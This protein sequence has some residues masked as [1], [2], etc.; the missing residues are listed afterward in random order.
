MIKYL[1]LQRTTAAHGEEI[2]AAVRRVVE[3]GWYLLGNEVR[4]FEEDYAKYIGTDHCVACG[5]G[6]DALTL[7]LRAY[8]E[9]GVMKNGDEVIVP[10]NTYIATILAITATGHVP[11]RVETRLHTDEA[12]SHIASAFQIDDSLIE[13]AITERTRAIMIVHLYGACAYTERIGELCRKHNLKLIE[14]NAQAHGCKYCE[15]GLEGESAGNSFKQTKAESNDFKR[16]ENEGNSFKRTEDESAGRGFKLTGSLGDAA[17]HSFYPGKNLGALG[18]A[19]AVTTNDAELAQTIR[20]I[21]N[22]GSSRKYV[23]DYVGRNSRKD[24]LQAAVLRVKL[25][26]LDADN[27]RRREIARH[28]ISNIRHPKLQLPS[29]AYCAKSVHHIFPV[30]CEER[31]ALQQHLADSGIQTLIHYPVPPH[32]QQCYAEPSANS[33]WRPLTDQPLPITEL[34]HRQELSLPLYPALTDSEIEQ[35]INSVNCFS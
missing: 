16:T 21:A 31:D 5:N 35:I 11:R 4:A 33:D 18:D 30:L 1:D 6:L 34:I 8:K 29:E 12:R 9:L 19:G 13:A 22:Y 32:R 7:I 23:F 15:G 24:E 2:Q 10:A 28:Y 25:Q 26:Y 27:R 14:D 20:A 3:S 17:A